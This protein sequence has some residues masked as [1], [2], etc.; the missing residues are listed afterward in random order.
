M[1]E[2]NNKNVRSKL[3]VGYCLKDYFYREVIFLKKKSIRNNT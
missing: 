2:V 1:K 3:N